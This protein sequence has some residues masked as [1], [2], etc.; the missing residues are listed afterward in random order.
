MT[1]CVFPIDDKMSN[2]KIQMPL[3]LKFSIYSEH[4]I[5]IYELYN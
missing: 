2:M 5:Y 4:V 3:E 1:T